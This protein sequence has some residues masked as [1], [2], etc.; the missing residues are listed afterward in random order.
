MRM[1]VEGRRRKRTLKVDRQCKGRLEGEATV[2]RGDAKH[3]C[4]EATY[5]K[6]RPL[7]R[8]GKICGGRRACVSV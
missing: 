4:V 1:D 6:H 3:S 5:Q 7:H 8:N 2:G